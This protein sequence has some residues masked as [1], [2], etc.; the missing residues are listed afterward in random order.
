MSSFFLGEGRAS[1]LR[2]KADLI[3]SEGRPARVTNGSAAANKSLT[4]G[5]SGVLGGVYLG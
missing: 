1:Q 5:N 3:F 4:V 2:G